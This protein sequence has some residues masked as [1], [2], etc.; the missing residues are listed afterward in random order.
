MRGKV[1]AWLFPVKSKRITPA[2]AGKR[3]TLSCAAGLREDHPRLCGEKWYNNRRG[4]LYVGSPPPMRGKVT[5]Q[6]H[7]MDH[8]G[9]TPA[10]AGKSHQ[11]RSFS[12]C[13]RDHPRLCGEKST[14]P[15]TGAGRRG[16]PPPMRGKE[17]VRNVLKSIIRI[18]PAYAGKSGVLLLRVK[19]P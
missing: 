5:V 4:E 10:Y 12:F 18:T 9:I 13:W 15:A 1:P 19:N 17:R 16:S 11:S 7:A 14:P 2:Y 6:C 8:G 3:E